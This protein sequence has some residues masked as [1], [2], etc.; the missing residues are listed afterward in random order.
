MTCRSELRGLGGVQDQLQKRGGGL[1][2]IS[3]D[4]VKQNKQ[5][6][7]SQQLSF[8]VLSDPGA[9]LIREYGL[10]HQGLGLGEMGIAVPAQFLLDQDR[11]ILWRHV[12]HRVT[13]RSD[14]GVV[15]RVILKH[16]P[17]R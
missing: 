14:P 13:N 11:H 16:W 9:R 15:L 7:E 3:V 12:A 4:P 17:A 8:Q 10:L 5:L 1:L 2:A 6:A